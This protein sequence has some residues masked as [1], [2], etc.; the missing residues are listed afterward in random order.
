MVIYANMD[1]QR[2][3]LGDVSCTELYNIRALAA[4]NLQTVLPQRER[5][6]EWLVIRYFFD[7]FDS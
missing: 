1:H 2:M 4:L 3:E 5:E 7:R 6:R